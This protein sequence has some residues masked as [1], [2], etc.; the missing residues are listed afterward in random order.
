MIKEPML[1]KL[2]KVAEWAVV[3]SMGILMKSSKCSSVVEEEWVAWEVCQ[4]EV[5]S[6]SDKVEEVEVVIAMASRFE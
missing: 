3:D 5:I 2:I 1:K 4:E 6:L